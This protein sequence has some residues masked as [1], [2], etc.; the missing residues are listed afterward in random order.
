MATS[1]HKEL[2]EQD[3]WQLLPGR[4]HFKKL[5]ESI[6]T[7]EFLR[8]EQIL[9]GQLAQ[10]KQL[11]QFCANEVP[12]YKGIFSELG[13]SPEDIKAV[14]DL[15]RLPFL[16]RKVVQ[17][18]GH[19]LRALKLPKGFKITGVNR[20]SGT[21][22]QPVEVV[23]TQEYSRSFHL[24]KQR[25]YRWF[26]FNP[27]EKLASIRNAL[28]LP[29]SSDG[30][31]LVKNSM[32][33]KSAWPS[34]GNFF[35]TGPW[36]GLTDTTSMD[37]QVRWLERY[38]PNYILGQSA[39]IEQL[40]LAYQGRKVYQE[41][42]AIEVI[43][44]QLTPEMRHRIETVFDVPVHQNYGLNEVGIVAARCPDEGRYHIHSEFC[45]V[46][47]VD[48]DGN[49]CRPG[50][51]GRL[52][53]T[54]LNNPAMPLIRYDTDDFAEAAD[55]PCSCGRTLPSFKDIH[56]RYRRTTLCPP[57]TWQYWD[58]ILATV[59]SDDLQLT[60]D[61]RQYQLHQYLDKSFELRLVAENPLPAEFQD[62]LRKNWEK[63]VKGG[64]AKLTIKYVG[65]I[66]RLNG[67][68]FQNFT[69]DFAPLHNT[70]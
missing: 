62:L 19:R 23:Q 59:S 36:F 37:D 25:E 1:L 69:S 24:M 20:T 58:A 39:L 41:I 29:R 12:Y 57:E 3:R 45:I 42:L 21:T 64:A 13:F 15:V 22:G 6:I 54:A 47:I 17:K 46:E 52:L 48:N 9:A 26:R 27:E 38:R 63:A 40:S 70:E 33:Q 14:D 35:K 53:I 49:L 44:Q 66:E 50:E 2:K 51:R 67:G 65:V 34:V 10:L 28:D 4:R 8:V 31:P 56:G 68:K 11:L 7:N 43:S 32:I 16:G 61:L 18:E 60:G 30:K 5:F 55:G